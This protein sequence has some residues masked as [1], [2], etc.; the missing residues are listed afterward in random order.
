M[1]KFMK[2]ITSMKPITF[3]HFWS[4]GCVQCRYKG[5]TLPLFYHLK[6]VMS[7]SSLSSLSIKKTR[8]SR[9]SKSTEMNSRGYVIVRQGNVQLEWFSA[10]SKEIRSGISCQGTSDS[11]TKKVPQSGT[12]ND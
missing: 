8:S 1:P 10:D 9:Q 6:D 12:S 4:R 5:V 3:T 2:L 11:L 7:Y